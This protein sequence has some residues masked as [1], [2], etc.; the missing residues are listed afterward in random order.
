[1][2][3]FKSSHFKFSKSQRNGNFLLIL[4]VII[5]QCLYFFVEFSSDDVIVNQKE[6]SKFQNEIDSLKLVEI[7]VR[8]PKIYSFNPNY[9]TD[10]KGASLGMTNDEIDRLLNFRKQNKWI[11]SVEQFHDV[12]QI[13][14]SLLDAMSPYFKFPD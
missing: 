5:L 9:I 7:E 8:K 10:F 14:D 2:N 12:T 6:L 13:S 4:L 11:N 1:M 3:V